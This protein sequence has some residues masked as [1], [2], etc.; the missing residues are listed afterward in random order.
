MFCTPSHLL[1]ISSF[2]S[3]QDIPFVVSY[4]HHLFASF[5]FTVCIHLI[6]LV[7]FIACLVIFC[8]CLL[9]MLDCP[10]DSL[11]SV[12]LSVL[13]FVTS[14]PTFS[15]L[16]ASMY[17]LDL[18]FCSALCYVSTWCLHFFIH[19]IKKIREEISNQDCCHVT[20][21]STI[22]FQHELS[23]LLSATAEEIKN[24]I[25]AAKNSTCELDPLLTSLLKDCVDPLLSHKNHE[26]IFNNWN[27]SHSS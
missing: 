13:F 24:N 1:I 22:T 3:V 23:D 5:S 27:R 11:N 21:D 15:N 18:E 6:F 7:I 26:F 25:L 10:S 16:Y 12:F 19:K 4:L 9:W 8:G 17:G 2:S 20:T 14:L